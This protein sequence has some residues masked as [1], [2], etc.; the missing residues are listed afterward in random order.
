MAVGDGTVTKAHCTVLA[1]ILRLE[2]FVPDCQADEPQGF[3]AA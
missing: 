3:Y 1:G 2:L